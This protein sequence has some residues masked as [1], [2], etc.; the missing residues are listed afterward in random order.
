MKAMKLLLL[1][2][3]CGSIMAHPAGLLDRYVYHHLPNRVRKNALFKLLKPSEQD[4]I[5]QVLPEEKDVHLSENTHVH[6]PVQNI[7]NKMALVG[8]FVANVHDALSKK[9]QL[10]SEGETTR[11]HVVTK[12]AIETGLD[13]VKDVAVDTVQDTIVDNLPDSV[14]ELKLHWTL[15]YAANKVVAA[16]LGCAYDRTAGK[17]INFGLSRVGLK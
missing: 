8:A 15:K 3:F 10:I 2:L 9:A 14:R 13:I 7:A 4:I 11:F 12:V 6:V 1:S 17:V 5:A 16:A